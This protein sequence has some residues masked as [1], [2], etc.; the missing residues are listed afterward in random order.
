MP[1]LVEK[2]DGIALVTIDR[3]TQSNSIDT[4]THLELRDLWPVLEA[5]DTVGVI[6]LTGQGDKVFCAGA[7]ISSFLP[8]LS[9][10][11]AADDDPGDFCGLTHRRLSKVV[12]AAINGA[13]TGGGLEL[14]LACDLRISVDTAIFALPEVKIGA[15][16]GA[17]GVARLGRA[18]PDAVAMDMLLT[19]RSITAERAYQLGLVSEMLT[20]E[21]F[22]PRVR[23][24]AGMIL[25][26]SPLA[27]R[28]TRQI[29]RDTAQMEDA[30]ALSLE[31]EA[32]WDVVTSRDFDIGIKSF[33]ARTTPK[34]EGV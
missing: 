23:E 11:I 15:I 30:E 17:G 3:P 20:R 29:A 27:V 18:L 14:A 5:D 13:A 19:G 10:R 24:I 26:N 16:A 8:Y 21:D 9:Q 12:I 7:D 28:L 2:K 6:I 33:V 25:R 22:M 34:F 1:V 4:E 32:F 31:R